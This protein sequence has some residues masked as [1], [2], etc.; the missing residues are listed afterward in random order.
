MRTRGTHFLL[1]LFGQSA[2][3]PSVGELCSKARGVFSATNLAND[4]YRIPQNTGM[5]VR[6]KHPPEESW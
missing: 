1:L 2:R 4:A 6:V 3:G 5:P